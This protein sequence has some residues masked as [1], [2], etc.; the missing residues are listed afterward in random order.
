[1]RLRGDSKTMEYEVYLRREVFDFLRGLRREDREHLL[2]L[3]RKLGRDPF[4]RGDFSERDLAGREVQGLI[5]RRYAVLYWADHAV[6][7]V[8]VAD[9]RSAD[10]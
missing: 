4:R 9:I 7:E 5:T 8:K 1:M 6:K 3:L 2:T 10:S